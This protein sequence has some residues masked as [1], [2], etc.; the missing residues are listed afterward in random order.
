MKRHCML[1]ALVV[2]AAI[3]LPANMWAQGGSTGAI[4]GVVTDEKGGVIV[5]AKIGV[6]NVDTGTKA[7]EVISTGAGTYAVPLLPP[8][9]YRLEVTANG[10][11]TFIAE[12][13]LVQVTET[14]TVNVVLKVGEITEKIIVSAV[15]VPVDLTNATTGQTIGTYTVSTLPLSTRNT[16]LL[17]T[18]SAGANTEIFASAAFGTGS[19]QITIDVNG[20]RPV[21]NN[22]QL[23]GLNVNDVNLPTFTFIPTPNP[24]TV[25]EF[26][27]QTSLYDASQGRNGGGNVQVDLRPG[28]SQ[29]HGNAYEFFRN[30]VLNANDFFLNRDGVPRPLLRQNQYGTSLGGP[31]PHIPIPLFKKDL[32]FFV[33]WQETRQTSGIAP[34][35]F[36]TTQVPVLPATRDAATLASTFLAG[37]GY[38]AADIDPVALKFLNLPA[39][40]CPLFNDGTLC[41]PTLAGT[42]GFTGTTLNKASLSASGFGT[43]VEDQF[44]ANIDKQV[45]L[46]DK[47]MIHTFY[48]NDAKQEPFGTASSL[49]FPKGFPSKN[50]FI[51]LGW[52]HVFSPSV[53][54]DS[55][56]GLNRFFFGQV[57]SEPILL[58]DIGATRGNSGQFPAA[59]RIAISGAGAPNLSIGTGVNDDRG[60]TF[61]TFTGGNDLSVTRGRHLVRIGWEFDRYQLNRFNNFAQRGS[62]TFGNTTAGAPFRPGDPALVGFQ[63]FLL[64]HITA[65]QAGAGFSSFHFRALDFAGYIQDDFKI[66]PR[67]T[68]NLGIRWEGLSTAHERNNF[69]SNF[70]GNGDG[71]S[72]PLQIIHPRGTPNVGT[73]GVSSCTLQECFSAGNWAPRVSFAWDI[74]GDQKTVLRAGYGVYYQRISNQ[75]LLQ[76]SGGLPFSQAVSAAR[77][78]VTTA[79]PF[80]SILPNSAFPLPFDQVVPTLAAF[81]DANGADPRPGCSATPLPAGCLSTRASSAGAPIFQ[82]AGGGPLSGFFFF[83]NRD[84]RPPYAQQWNLGIQRQ[85]FKGWMLE[86]GYVGTKG[87]R[88]LGPGDPTNPSKICTTL[89]PC[90]IPANIGTNVSVSAGTPFVTKNPDGTISIT[91]ST[92]VNRN[93]RVPVADLGLATSRGF[94]QTQGGDS[95]YHSLQATVSHRFSGGLYLQGAYTWSK[96]IDNSS[97]SLFTDELNGLTGFG[98]LFNSRQQRGLSDFDRTH[99][100]VVSYNYELPFAKMFHIADH[101]I[102]GRAV[103]GWAVNGVTTIQSGTPFTVIDSSALTLQDTEGQNGTNF[104]TLAPGRTLQSAIVPGEVHARIDGFLDPAAFT[105]SGNCV[106]NQNNVVSFSDPSC[107]GFAAVG[108][109]GRNAFRGPFQQNFDISV[110]KKTRITEKTAIELRAELFNAFNH[111][112]FAGPQGGVG[113][114]VDISASSAIVNTVNSPRIVQFSLKASF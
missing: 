55:R 104:A 26:K 107:T 79:N 33:N 2:M 75:S 105:V 69:L 37:T 11:A 44:V 64:G 30:D 68:L 112:S 102:L 39:S 47:V 94:F 100:I 23:E 80:P 113:A 35:T 17:L 46:N 10:F 32:F 45:G 95:N 66:K 29:Y 85:L 86:V 52:S 78:S 56:F 72:G 6:T 114:I 110:L 3:C 111:P 36:F 70:A 90:I 19:D 106:D 91:A 99:R 22:I 96:S 1:V 14:T 97:G 81:R 65:T 21:N 74:F 77:F 108:N 54:L 50:R 12:R 109:L 51:K 13:V 18:L 49:S 67:L 41:I 58:T 101:G 16:M 40:K 7:R 82:S 98:D 48:A 42:P 93:A 76:T 73:P 59:Y 63:N 61:N 88:L 4:A 28:T 34:G 9:R 8:G 31:V 38:T 60:G 24:E 15:E 83:P 57:P 62:V 89:R 71:T 25:Q 43:F 5:G 87:V 92:D 20:Q 103:N 84:F 27:I 53:V